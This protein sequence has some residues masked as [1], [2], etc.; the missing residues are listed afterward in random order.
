MNLDVKSIS[1][2]VDIPISETLTRS[3]GWV[4]WAMQL[5]GPQLVNMLWRILGSEPDV[6]DAYQQ[7]F[8]NL[9]HCLQGQK[10]DNVKAYVF[11]TAS[12]IASSMLRRKIIERK[13]L[14]KLSENEVIEQADNDVDTAFLRQQLR[15]SIAK[16][17][18]NLREV[19]MLHDLA[20]LPYA[21]VAKIL[22]FTEATVRVYRCK[23]LQLLSVLMKK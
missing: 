11:R 1:L 21:K 15:S 16:L 22:G 2:D 6:C 12:N 7:T 23:A 20:E 13:N 19:V 17:P 8:L 3:Q 5:Y 4:L 10:P 14:S 18:E 9:A